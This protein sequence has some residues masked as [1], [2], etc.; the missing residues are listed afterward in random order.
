[1][2]VFREVPGHRLQHGMSMHCGMCRTSLICSPAHQRT[3]NIEPNLP[4]IS[5]S[6]A[7]LLQN[8]PGPP[9]TRLDRVELRSS[10]GIR[11]KGVGIRLSP[12]A[13]K[14]LPEDWPLTL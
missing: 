9:R 4:T 13:Y 3:L 2:V 5:H 10:L 8:S 1:M 6:S 14:S 11:L 7:P 12:E